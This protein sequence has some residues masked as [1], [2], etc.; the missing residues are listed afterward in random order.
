MGMWSEMGGGERDEGERGWKPPG[1]ALDRRQLLRS[2]TLERSRD[3]H[4]PA[5][6]WVS[7]YSYCVFVFL[8]AC[9]GA[10]IKLP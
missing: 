6:A 4:R 10:V 5:S 7:K 8:G 3:S 2:C 9:E 1:A